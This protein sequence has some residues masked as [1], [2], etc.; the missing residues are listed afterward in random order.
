ML[1]LR[2]DFYYEIRDEILRF[3]K[4]EGHVKW[5]LKNKNGGNISVD[6]FKLFDISNAFFLLLSILIFYCCAR[7]SI[8]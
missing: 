6:K 5:W 3:I 1:F 7:S 4:S 8:G 2:G